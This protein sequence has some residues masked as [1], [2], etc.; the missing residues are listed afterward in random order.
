MKGRIIASLTLMAVVLTALFI[1]S[2]TDLVIKE[3]ENTVY[4]IAVLVDAADDVGWDNFRLG[5]DRAA[6]DMREADIS[7]V[8]LYDEDQNEQQLEQLTREI[9]GGTQ[10]II[11]KAENL[12]YQSVMLTQMPANVPVVIYGTALESPRVKGVIAS[13]IE[14]MMEKLART[15][16]NDAGGNGKHITI[17]TQ[18]DDRADV[19]TMTNVITSQLEAE[20]ETVERITLDSLDDAETLVNG[21]I[22]RGDSMVFAPELR[23]ALRLAEVIHTNGAALPLYT[24][25]WSSAARQALDRGALR[26]TATIDEFAAGYWA[27][28]EMVAQLSRKP[29]PEP[30]KLRVSVVTAASLYSRNNQMMLFPIT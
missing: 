7:F 3:R 5:M 27:I 30:I 11:L 1:V 23:T 22:A 26:A 24:T 18:T 6:L 9:E 13:P 21:L 16:L 29:S 19:E 17:V 15:M 2:S 12:G 4:S 14:E 28:Q 10:G 8:T 25:G 20:G